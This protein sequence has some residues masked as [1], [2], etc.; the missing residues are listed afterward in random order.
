MIVL[1]SPDFSKREPTGL[2]DGRFSRRFLMLCSVDCWIFGEPDCDA[3]GWR[4]FRF[5]SAS[6]SPGAAAL[7]MVSGP[8]HQCLHW[9][10]VV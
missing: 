7:H 9:V 2:I 10:L 8:T 6:A 4:D 1:P 5:R 3:I